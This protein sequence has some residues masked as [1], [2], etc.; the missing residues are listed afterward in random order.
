MAGAARAQYAPA[1]PLA[2]PP[3]GTC[4]HGLSLRRSLH[5]GPYSVAEVEAALGQKVLRACSGARQ[6]LT[7]GG[8]SWRAADGRPGEPAAAGRGTRGAEPVRCT[9]AVAPRCDL[10]DHTRAR[11][12]SFSCRGAPCTSSPKRR[13]FS[14]SNACAPAPPATRRKPRCSRYNCCSAGVRAECRARSNWESCSL[15]ATRRAPLTTSARARSSVGTLAASPLR[16]RSPPVTQTRWLASARKRTIVVA[17]PAMTAR[18]RRGAGALG[19]RL[20]GAG[21]GGCAISL[22]RDGD[23]PR[24]VPRADGHRVT[25]A[26]AGCWRPR[27]GRTTLPCRTRRSAASTT[28]SS[29]RPG[30]GPVRSASKAGD[31]LG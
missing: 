18:A 14:T 24:W 16:T 3:C 21:W 25:R 13:A 7:L 11:T 31:T 28:A 30:Q 17:P 6:L 12:A 5:A 8:R 22:V 10:A 26:A 19:A 4:F 2:C 27:S 9:A 29:A 1:S 15:R 23:I 20:T